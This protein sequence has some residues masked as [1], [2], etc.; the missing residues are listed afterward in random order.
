MSTTTFPVGGR[1]IVE[2]MCNKFPDLHTNDDDKQRK[3]TTRIN[4]Q[5]AFTFGPKWGGKVRTGLDPVTQRSKD[6]Q[7]VLESDGTC[8]VWDLFQGNAEATILVEDGSAPTHANL[9]PDAE[10]IPCTPRDW[11]EGGVPQPEP[12]PDG[13]MDERV[14]RLELE[15]QAQ[16]AKIDELQ[17]QNGL[18]QSQVDELLARMTALESRALTRDT[19]LRVL[20][21]TNAGSWPR[22]WH[23]VDLSVTVVD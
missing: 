7:A 23:D 13:E 11:L 21:R 16:A 2:R 12:P 6:S 5:F 8:S 9:G 10:F 4:E 17:Y 3:L 19:N 22:H 14:R 18:Q 20:G 15:N 1:D